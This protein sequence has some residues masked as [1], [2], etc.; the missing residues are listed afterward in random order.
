MDYME[1]L[2][3]KPQIN[4]SLFKS[5]TFNQNIRHSYSGNISNYATYYI[6]IYEDPTYTFSLTFNNYF[7][8]KY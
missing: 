2:K 6:P 4:L 7:L 1:S 3:L 8:F 5:V